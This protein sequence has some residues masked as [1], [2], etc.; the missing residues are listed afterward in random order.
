MNKTEMESIKQN[1]LSI[2]LNMNDFVQF[3]KNL[4]NPE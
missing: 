4:H 1:F 3:D 2:N